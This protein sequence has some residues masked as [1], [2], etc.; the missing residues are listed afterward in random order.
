MKQAEKLDRLNLF[1]NL[2]ERALDPRQ[3]DKIWLLYEARQWTYKAFYDTVLVVG[4]WLKNTHGVQKNEIVA[5]DCM[6]HPYAL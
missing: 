5:L 4:Q 1:Y 2:E 3:S 6:N